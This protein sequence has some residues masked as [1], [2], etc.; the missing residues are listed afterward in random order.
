MVRMTVQYRASPMSAKLPHEFGLV[1][2]CRPDSPTVPLRDY[3]T[4]ESRI[5]MRLV[6]RTRIP[7]TWRE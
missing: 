4:L 6:Q 3:D 7:L 1:Y 2:A 5:Q